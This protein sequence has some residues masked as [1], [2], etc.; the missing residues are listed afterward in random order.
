MSVSNFQINL[1]ESFERLP[2]APIVE[3][4]IHWRAQPAQKLDPKQFLQELKGRLPEY[5][6]IQPQVELAVN[7][8]VG[9]DGATLSQS[10]AWQAFQLRTQDGLSVAQF[11]RNGLVFSRL[12][13]YEKWEPFRDEALRLWDVFR[14]FAAPPEVQ[15]LGVRYI[16]LVPVDAIDEANRLLSQPIHFPGELDLPTEQ[17]THQTRF[18]IPG[19]E[20]ALNLIRTVQ[21]TPPNADHRI[22]LIV[23]IDVFTT[24]D[25]LQNWPEDRDNLLAELRWIKNKT[26]FTT[27]DAAAIDQFKE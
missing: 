25:K 5:P 19:R 2:R 23:D 17:F 18:R 4:V 7:H 6:N 10:H 26:F 14:E 27:F 3:A 16:N 12:T 8:Q 13:P 24:S 1:D 22:N 20:Y 9:P 11:G 21:Q 15:R